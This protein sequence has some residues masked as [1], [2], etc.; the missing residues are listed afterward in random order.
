MHALMSGRLQEVEDSKDRVLEMADVVGIPGGYTTFWWWLLTFQLLRERDRLE[1]FEPLH[2]GLLKDRQNTVHGISIADAQAALVRALRLS[3]RGSLTNTS[4]VS[5]MA[6]EINSVATTVLG[7]TR[8]GPRSN[9]IY[10]LVHLA[11]AAALI[12]DS[13][14]SRKL[15]DLLAPVSTFVATTGGSFMTVGSI[16]HYC[17]LLASVH[18]EWDRAERYFVE[19]VRTNERLG[20]RLYMARSRLSW[21]ELLLRRKQEGDLEQAQ[22]MLRDVKSAAIEMGSFAM[23]RQADELLSKYFGDKYR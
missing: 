8:F 5:E 20:A 19:A 2:A 9:A 14:C 4:A 18:G 12:G 16:A 3:D 15:Y 21:A 10:A 7:N 11:E 6:E 1:D 22:T 13:Q 23:T 17:G